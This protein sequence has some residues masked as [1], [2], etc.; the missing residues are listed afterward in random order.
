M[1]YIMQ[2]TNLIL[3]KIDEHVENF[4]DA[5]NRVRNSGITHHA[6]VSLSSSAKEICDSV[7]VNVAERL[8]FPGFL[9]LT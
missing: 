7:K 8:N 1:F 4:Q 3:H 6:K 5:V 2:S 9:R